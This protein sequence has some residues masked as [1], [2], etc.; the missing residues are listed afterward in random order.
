MEIDD[1]DF[2]CLGIPSPLEMWR[3]Q[4]TLLSAEIEEHQA[5]LRRCRSNIARLV[6]INAALA[7]ER[8]ELDAEV[9]RL[10]WKLSD[11][12][13][14]NSKLNNALYTYKGLVAEY[15]PHRLQPE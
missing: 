13:V 1:S 12:Y 8:N 7:L 6:E 15:C 11:T 4:A 10:R 14:E 2:G 9:N 3:Q 5:D